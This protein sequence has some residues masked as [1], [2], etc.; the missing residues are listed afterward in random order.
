VAKNAMITLAEMCEGFKKSMD[1]FLEAIFIKLF[2]KAQDA[3]SF[4][5]EEVNKCV[6]SL[7]CYCS[8]GKISAIIVSNSQ[9]KA[10]PIKLKVALTLKQLL[11]KEGFGVH[12]L[13]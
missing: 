7:C 1:P 4:I 9:A 10:I 6:K 3:N 2:K 11:E 8:S 5:I 13:K 12:L